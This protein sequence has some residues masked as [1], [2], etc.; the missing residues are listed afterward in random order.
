MKFDTNK[1]KNCFTVRL[2][3]HWNRLPRDRDMEPS[4]LEI[5]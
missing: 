5:V 3:E 1:R 4:Y 2:R